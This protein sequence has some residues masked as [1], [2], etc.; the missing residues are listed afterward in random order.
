MGVLFEKKLNLK[1]GH[2]WEEALEKGNLFSRFKIEA[3]VGKIINLE[4][5]I[6]ISAVIFD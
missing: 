5:N 4:T 3:F 6:G 2:R 1:K